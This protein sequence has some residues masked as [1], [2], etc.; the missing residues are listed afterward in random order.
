MSSLEKCKKYRQIV[1]EKCINVASC[2]GNPRR[3]LTLH[4]LENPEICTKS[5]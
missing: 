2:I 1:L 3:H 5:D 4:S